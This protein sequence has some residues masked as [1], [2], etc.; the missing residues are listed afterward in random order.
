MSAVVL[1][2]KRANPP[3]RRHIQPNRRLIQKQ[4]FWP[5]QQRTRNLT[6]HALTQR[7]IAHPVFESMAPNPTVPPVQTR[8]P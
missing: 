8:S 6:L 1:R 2:N 5:M 3:L 7:Q 4:H